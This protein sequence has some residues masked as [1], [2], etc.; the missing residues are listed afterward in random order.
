MDNEN[1]LNDIPDIPA[2]KFDFAVHD[3]I[4]HDKKLETKPVGYF[5]GA[6]KRF[7][8]NKGSVVGAIVIAIL[9]LFAIIVPFC[10][11]YTVSYHDPYFITVMP[12]NPAFE[13]TSFWDGCKKKEIGT[14]SFIKD[15]AMG[16]ETGELVV[17]NNE[18]TYADG[19][20]TYRFD[21]YTSCGFGLYKT[22]SL[23][24]Y[25][26][27]QK[28]QDATGIQV[29][30]P[31]VD[32]ANRPEAKQ[33]T[34]N[35]NYYYKTVKK[36]GKTEP[37]LDNDGNVI[38]V[39][40]TYKEGQLDFD[41]GYSSKLR[42]EGENG[43]VD[44]DGDT[45]YYVYGFPVDG[46]MQCRI[47]YYNYYRYVHSWVNKDGIDR[48]VFILG[49]ETSGKDILTCLASGA[50]F[51]FIFAILV[52]IVNMVV[53]AIY[54]AIEGYYGGKADLIMERVSDIL[55]AVPFMIVITL[56]KLHMG[57]SS[58]MVILFISFFLT[59][60][61]GMAATTRMQFYRFKNQE[62]VLAARTLGAKDRRLMFKHIFPNAIGTLVTAFALVIPSMIYTETSM[63][64]LNIINLETGN[65][66]S[67]GTLIANGQACMGTTP[68]VVLFP[69]IF[70]VLLMLSF[71][72]FGNGLRDA[73]N[74]SLRGAEG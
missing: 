3:D 25:E 2:E 41:D 56:L 34:N 36:A 38:P 16:Q 11:P 31:S 40:W 55:N 35:A 30:F 37:V 1:V 12:R 9:I 67:V 14:V 22:I 53:G 15:Y 68:H 43:F 27:I 52:A 57:T 50:R 44:D 13:N 42:L 69:S 59:G 26:D 63:T 10:T 74:P 62:Y 21:T 39:Y 49:T 7:C 61:I 4:V 24:E 33:D 46:G 64:Y 48:P 51:S 58:D 17:K 45:C 65:L 60:W 19:L 20:Y 66:T 28:Y 32:A 29:I 6:F 8:K 54:G 71:N 18:Y 73:F 72:L 70:L 47:F 5:K 23:A